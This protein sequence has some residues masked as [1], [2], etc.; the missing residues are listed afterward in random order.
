M[1][2]DVVLLNSGLNSKSVHSACNS[3]F[4]KYILSYGLEFKTETRTTV[5]IINKIFPDAFCIMTIPKLDSTLKFALGL[6]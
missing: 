6:A 3:S 2:T 4:L 1:I 5:E